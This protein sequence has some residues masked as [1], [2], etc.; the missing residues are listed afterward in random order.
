MRSALILAA[1]LVA[2]CSTTPVGP[3][4][5]TQCVDTAEVSSFTVM[6]RHPHEIQAMFDQT[7]RSVRT[8]ATDP[9]HI[10]GFTGLN[11][12]GQMTMALPTLRGQRDRERLVVWGHELAHV[13]CGPFHN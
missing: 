8:S 12:S 6:I 2:G 3:P 9:S 10:N 13:L 7:P 1:V 4:L 5:T 11:A